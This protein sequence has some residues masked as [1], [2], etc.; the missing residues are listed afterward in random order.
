[1]LPLMPAMSHSSLLMAP[2]LLLPA[3]PTEPAD[4]SNG[5]VSVRRRC[6]RRRR[7]RGAPSRFERIHNGLICELR[8]HIGGS[9]V[10]VS[11]DGA[12][13][14]QRHSLR[15]E[16]RAQR[17]PC[18]FVELAARD[19]SLVTGIVPHPSHGRRGPPF[20]GGRVDKHQ[21]QKLYQDYQ[22]IRQQGIS[23]PLIGTITRVFP[24]AARPLLKLSMHRR[25]IDFTR[26]VWVLST[27]PGEATTKGVGQV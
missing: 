19:A 3:P 23:W 10:R 24:R 14:I 25:L 11:E 17:V 13:D 7:H 5:L 1:M 20:P 18:A 21:I 22:I 9:L 6:P 27:K 8:V 16:L 2:R 26:T 4:V 12:D 15:T